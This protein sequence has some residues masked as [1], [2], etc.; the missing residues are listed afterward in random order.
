M[1][2]KQGAAVRSRQRVLGTIWSRMA[3][4]RVSSQWALLHRLVPRRE[5]LTPDP[6]ALAI[7]AIDRIGPASVRACASGIEVCVVVPDEAIA[8]VLRA[9]L[10]QTAQWRATDSLIRIS[11]GR[12]RKFGD[13]SPR[14]SRA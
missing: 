1:M 7:C 12:A 13:Y 10:A 14:S 6:V 4:K 11:V 5:S 2:A 8:A 9:A 3:R